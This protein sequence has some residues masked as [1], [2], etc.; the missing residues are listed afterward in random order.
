MK[1]LKASP[2]AIV[3]A[4]RIIRDG[5]LIAMPTETVYGLAADASNAMAVARIFEAKG[6]PSFNPLIVH[7]GDIQMARRLAVF[8]DDSEKLAMAFW[9][10]PLTLVLRRREDAGV[11]D[12]VTAGLPTIAI[13]LPAHPT[14]A[15]LLHAA[16]TPIA[17]PS[18][19]RSGHV[20]PTTADH[21]AADLAGQI[22][23]ILDAGACPV[24]I[25]S[26]VV[27]CS[28]ISDGNE[29]K[30]D[31]AP[32]LLR[33]G[34]ISAEQIGRVLGRPPR[35]AAGDNDTAPTSPGQLASHYAPNARMRLNVKR[36]EP[37]E[38]LL[39]FGPKVP[40]HCGLMINLSPSGDLKEAAANL[41]ASLRAL[42]SE[43]CTSIAVVTIPGEGLGEA[44][45]D[46]LLRAAAP[47]P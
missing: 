33:P 22:D 46:R 40:A 13:R 17:A 1:T 7:V 15:K 42:D 27:D 2:P 35:K 37:G 44:I 12:L 47:R 14:T 16:N 11:S 18:A 6:R 30:E 23:M 43:G 19:N 28:Q 8:T 39:A 34:G 29:D 38:A 24:G 32:T 36:P 31:A 21:V 41:F 5:G 10:G 9:P 25:E 20:S 3:E 26:T 45:N 4:A